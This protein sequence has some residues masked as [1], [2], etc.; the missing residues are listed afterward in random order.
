M[1]AIELTPRQVW[2]K[3]YRPPPQLKW[4]SN[5]TQ[6]TNHNIEHA[7]NIKVYQSQ[8]LN[9]EGAVIDALNAAVPEDYKLEGIAFSMGWLAS[10]N[11]RDIPAPRWKQHMT[12]QHHET[13]RTTSGYH[14]KSGSI[15]RL[16]NFF[17][18][19]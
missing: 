10:M 7:A 17:C 12:F 2:P 9:M 19:G 3:Q 4:Q 11:V 1:P 15:P 14:P 5:Y 6:K 16:P 13:R 8:E 18:M